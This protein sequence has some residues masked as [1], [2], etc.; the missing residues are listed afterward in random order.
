[1]S[2]PTTP[3]FVHAGTWDDETRK[4]PAMKWMEEYTI[5]FNKRGDW[6]QEESDWVSLTPSNLRTTLQK[7]YH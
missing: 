7:L 5:N 3:A 1:M 2:V 6:D 4:H